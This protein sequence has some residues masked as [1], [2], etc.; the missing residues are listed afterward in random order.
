MTIAD[1]A[2]PLRVLH[3]SPT[4]YPATYFGGPIFSTR[5]ICDNV[6]SDETF[7]IEVLTTNAAGS[8]RSEELSLPSNPV[9]FPAGYDV[10]YA[11]RRFVTSVS[12]ELLR[13][14]PGL[15]RKAQ[16]VH[17]TGTYSFPTI[18]TLL[19][20][21]IYRKPV[22]WSPRGALQATQEWAGAP[23]RQAKFL[24]ELIC[25]PLCGRRTV[26]HVTS[27]QEKSLSTR[28]LRNVEA[29]IIPNSV[30]VPSDLPLREWRPEGRLRLMFLSRI[31]QKKG[32]ENLLTSMTLLPEWVSLDVYGDGDKEYVIQIKDM[33][34]KL[35]LG[36]RVT[37]H[38]QLN[39]HGKRQAF[40]GA[41]VFI[42][43]TYSE[44]YGIAVAE[45]LAHGVPVITTKYA[46]WGGIAQRSCGLWL[47]DNKP[48]TLK[49]AIVQ[50]CNTDLPGA[51]MRGRQW[52]QEDY[53]ARTMADR[54]KALYRRQVL[55]G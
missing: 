32:I 14:L 9:R 43:P 46:P 25:R 16:V 19:L 3:V 44:N 5:A 18:P 8:K 41:D 52:M 40:A 42:L 33:A 11:K 28:R 17:L 34:Q 26:L 51:G 12:I 50:I 39:E 38:G 49:E 21:N 48:D 10:Y 1:K 31:H 4:Y 55:L 30:D 7:S 54:F 13:R 24:F 47:D 37:F 20:A 23:N 29:V 6:A 27:T 36:E 15:I 22:I 35:A 53:S 2:N 45:A